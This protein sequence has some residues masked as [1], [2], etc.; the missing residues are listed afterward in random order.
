MADVKNVLAT[1]SSLENLR[2]NIS[3]GGGKDFFDAYQSAESIKEVNVH[4]RILGF[5]NLFL[6]KLEGFSKVP[7]EL[8]DF[9]SKSSTKIT[10]MAF[11]EE[12]KKILSKTSKVREYKKS[13][14]I[15]DSSYMDADTF[16][17]DFLPYFKK[18]YEEIEEIK[19]DVEEH[20]DEKMDEFYNNSVLLLK[21]LGLSGKVLKRASME[22][23]N[24][25]AKANPGDVLSNIGISLTT[26]FEESLCKDPEL[27]EVLRKSKEEAMEIFAK[28]TIVS[29]VRDCFDATLTYVGIVNKTTKDDLSHLSLSKDRLLKA[30]NVIKRRNVTNEEYVCI[31]VSAMEKLATYDDISS[32]LDTGLSILASTYTVAKDY[33]ESLP[34]RIFT[35]EDMAEFLEDYPDGKIVVW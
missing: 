26:G 1:L 14:S 4:G 29:L 25:N 3:E 21:E 15:G 8:K 28:N 22:L 32:A 31:V 5:P 33:G 11:P 27:E 20:F 7:D 34:L 6:G 17:D 16:Y 23:E 19:K 35:E 30:V 13:R 10:L 2:K 18:V 9:A 24:I 12:R